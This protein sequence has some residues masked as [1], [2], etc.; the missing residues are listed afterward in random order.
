[1]TI[2]YFGRV[3]LLSL[4]A[5]VAMTDMAAA[6]KIGDVLTSTQ[7][8]FADFPLLL[9]AVAYIGGIYLA[10]IAVFKFK[11]H[12]DNPTHHPLSAAVKRFLAGGMLLTAPYMYD[13]IR[14]S[15][16]AD[17]DTN[18]AFGNVHKN[19]GGGGMDQMVVDVVSNMIGPM[20]NLLIAFTWIAGLAFLLMGIMR[21][22]KTAQ[23]GPRGPAGF[24]TIMTF[25]VSG[26][27]FSFGPSMAVFSTSL[28]GDAT[29]KTYANISTK[30]ISDA[31][32]SARVSAVVEAVMAFVAIVGFIAF[33]R[34]WF[35]LRNFAD[36]QQGA[37]LAQ[38]LTF[39]FGGALAINLGELVN[40][41]QTTVGVSGI[42]FS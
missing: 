25:I 10:A 8:A 37:T 36:G 39:L 38:G 27:L 30:V 11:D 14:G 23:E 24:G 28:F 35:V 33:I 20:T 16:F 29:V 18:M 42:T 34:G 9:S 40:V 15:I 31:S 13:V 22:T 2:N 17:S 21:L 12:V 7:K 1:M 4:V 5:L 41:L 26:A 19:P 6:Q 32:D 3:L